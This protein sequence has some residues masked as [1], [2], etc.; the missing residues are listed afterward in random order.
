[1]SDAENQMKHY[2]EFDY[3]VI[4][5]IFED[6]LSNL[7]T[8]IHHANENLNKSELTLEKQVLRHKYLLKELI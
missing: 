8:I 5:D 4:N 6:A 2:E 1:M 3:L 7:K